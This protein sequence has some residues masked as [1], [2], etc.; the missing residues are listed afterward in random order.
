LPLAVVLARP[1]K[2]KTIA[3]TGG[4]AKPAAGPKKLLNW[5]CWQ[6]QLHA[7]ETVFSPVNCRRRGRGAEELLLLPVKFCSQH[8]H[9]NCY[10][11]GRVNIPALLPKAVVCRRRIGQAGSK[12]EKLL[13]PPV[14]VEFPAFDA[15]EA[16]V[17]TG[18]RARTGIRSDQQVTRYSRRSVL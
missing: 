12:A 11:C 10:R 7:K 17:D 8:C 16:L 3:A 14:V 5:H 18:R 2:P 6:F 9:Q 15:E 13:P 1:K 4:V